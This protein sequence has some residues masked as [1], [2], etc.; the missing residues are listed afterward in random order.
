V[1]LAPYLGADR[2][3]SVLDDAIAG[4]PADQI[5]VFLT[6]RSAVMMR[7]A[8]ARV[9]QPQD[10][11]SRQI[12]VRAVV[13]GSAARAATSSLQGVRCAVKAA[14]EQARSLAAAAGGRATA[15]AAYSPA[16]PGEVAPTD[17]GVWSP[18]TVAW[19]ADARSEQIRSAVNLASSHGAE[20]CGAFG[21]AATELAVVNS[22]GVRR[23][24]AA[25]EASVSMTAQVGDGS[26][27][28]ED[29]SRV[30]T[31]LHVDAMVE[32]LVAD[33]V[34]M[35]QPEAVRP[36]AF[37]V[38]FGPLATGELLSFLPAFGFTAPAVRAGVGVVARQTRTL[39]PL[40]TIADDATEGPGL[41]FP[42][43]MEGT[44]R[45]RVD[46]VVGGSVRD[47]V[48]D[49][50]SA[51]VTHGST[52]HAHIAREESS[53]PVAANLRLEPR[54]GS[55]AD[56]VSGVEDGVYVERLWYTRLV[57]AELG[58]I[59]GT[60]RDAAWRIED[61]RMTVPLRGTRFS[62]S[63]L[64]AF[65]RVDSVGGQVVTQPLMN[66]WNGCVSAPAIRVRGFRF[67]LPSPAGA[68]RETSS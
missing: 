67:G 38:V 14:C 52:G 59:A 12:M 15:V 61:G 17:I 46:L 39:S 20:I 45:R 27:H 11:A 13:D 25:T 21:T 34:R 62:E 26:A 43:D 3:Q 53:A 4:A 32:G 65:E 47:V 42:F 22:L 56:L 35:A 10:L 23:Y 48:S 19:D 29:L 7:F 24:A 57:D 58:T 16:A 68:K 36:G 60:T 5:E 51:E 2:A 64:D 37:D 66:V 18:A 49:L 1:T 8:G 41:P 31:D 55:T 30:A 40:L 50:A 28:R 54:C 6:T 63:A 44:S 9:H 33:A